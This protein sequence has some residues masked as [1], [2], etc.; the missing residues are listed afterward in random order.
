M[1]LAGGALV[2]VRGA[3]DLATD[4][5]VRLVRSGFRVVALEAERPTTIRRAV[6]LYESV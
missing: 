4:C 2:V 1:S 5:I 6:S 3:G